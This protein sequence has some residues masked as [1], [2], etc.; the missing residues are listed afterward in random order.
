M[1]RGAEEL[2][3]Q[4]LR[5]GPSWLCESEDVMVAMLAAFAQVFGRIECAVDT[6]HARTFVQEADGSWLDQHGLERSIPRGAGELDAAYRA[7]LAGIG[8]A[9]TKPAILA[10]VDALL[11]VGTA[12]MEEHRRDA[13]Y[14]VPNGVTVNLQE[15]AG[16]GRSYE[17]VRCFTLIIP[18]QAPE[19][20]HTAFA[21][22]NG[23]LNDDT[24]TFA[25]AESEAGNT[26]LVDADG[27][28]A[29]PKGLNPSDVY[30]QV[31]DAVDRLK[32]AGVTFRVLV[33]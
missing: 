17:A 8:D 1:A 15:F 14:A 30:A 18:D 27:A 11:D 31:F 6:M 26:W 13:A 33:E 12:S 9:V 2:Y 7:R 20:K 32:A 25:W 29:D 21:A 5:H 16:V 3:Q 19:P 24:R 23:T 4:L 28:Y 22:P 10:A